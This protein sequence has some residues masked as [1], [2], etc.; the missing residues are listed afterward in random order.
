MAREEGEECCSCWT[1]LCKS[2]ILLITVNNVAELEDF[3]V[4]GLVHL[5]HLDYNLGHWS[6][7]V[8]FYVEPV[9]VEEHRQLPCLLAVLLTLFEAQLQVR[10]QLLDGVPD[11]IASTDRVQQSVH[12]HCTEG[13][14]DNWKVHK[15]LILGQVRE[16]GGRGKTF[17]LTWCSVLIESR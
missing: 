6:T 9:H 7:R 17:E 8:L 4:I 13:N 2:R 1:V 12:V 10:L 14:D 16:G 5:D 15:R 3:R 11:D